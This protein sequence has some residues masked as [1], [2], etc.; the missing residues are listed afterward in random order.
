M[1]TPSKTLRPI[2]PILNPPE[3]AGPRW[4]FIVFQA[5]AA[6]ALGS[7]LAASDGTAWDAVRIVLLALAVLYAIGALLLL[8]S[9]PRVATIPHTLNT[10]VP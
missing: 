8:V 10:T 9:N 6:G 5:A 4:G 2:A 7:G 3:Q 1:D